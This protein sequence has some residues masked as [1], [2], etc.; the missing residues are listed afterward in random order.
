MDVVVH[1]AAK[2]DESAPWE[3]ILHC[4]VEGAYNVF[5]ASRQAGVGRVVSASSVMVSWGYQLDE[6]YKAIKEG[7]FQDVPDEIP[8]VTHRD[9]V[10]PTEPYSASKVWGEALARVY[11]DVHH[12]SCICLRIGWVNAQDRP[13]DPALV[14]VWSSQRDIV[15]LVE[16]SIN[17]PRALRF[18]IFYGVS[19]NRYRW[20][21]IQH[22]REALG[23]V[24]Q[25]RGEDHVEPTDPQDGQ[26]SRHN[27]LDASHQGTGG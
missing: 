9:P 26:S 4:N 2:A 17:A 24:P 18:D 14:P 21:D 22:A 15:Q 6:P 10:R 5:E 7:R 3:Q 12:L 11:A 13:W 27:P 1:M 20:V 8:I 16:R 19:D 23:Y 25:D